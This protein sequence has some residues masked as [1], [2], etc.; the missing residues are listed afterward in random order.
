[1]RF[2]HI[3]DLHIG[4]Q[5]D[6]YSLL[7]D[8]RFALDQLIEIAKDRQVDALVIAGD[9][10]D[11]SVPSAD[12]IGLF[13]AFLT[14]AN[15]AGLLCFCIPG[16]HDSAERVGYAQQLLARQGMYFPPLFDG[17]ITEIELPPSPQDSPSGAVSSTPVVF[18]LMPYLNPAK[19]R[20]FFPESDIGSSYTA[21][22]KTVL[23]TCNL[24]SAKW[25]VLIS[26]QFVTAGSSDV[27]RASEELNL[28]GVDN[29]DASVFDAFDY[30]ALGHVHRP[31]RVGR[32]TLRYA[33]SLLKYS[34]SEARYPKTA[35]LV[36]L[37]KKQND[38]ALQM[39][40]V[41]QTAPERVALDQAEPKQTQSREVE[42]AQTGLTYELIEIPCLHDLREIKGTL[43]ELTSAE[44][45]S[46]AD[47]E[48]YIVAVLTD[49]T[50][51]LDAMN[52]L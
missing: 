52:R 32:D 43:D 44:V 31:Q 40:E 4:K 47:S 17:T 10:Y 45:I 46:R 25:N 30:V 34:A 49:T 12:A 13:D 3:A 5:L 2:L 27:A 33:G 1:V 42:A 37:G 22:V 7:D 20:Q 9:V 41:G 14:Q 24:D 36:E 15:A 16:N 51:Q 19:V 21:A 6:G 38:D 11:K 39:A 28:G 23:E 35:V 26:H 50:P 18:W 48:D 29:V 8:Q